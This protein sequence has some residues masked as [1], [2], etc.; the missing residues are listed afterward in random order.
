MFLLEVPAYFSEE[1]CDYLIMLAKH[2]G[3]KKSPL[4]PT[5]FSIPDH[6]SEELFNEWDVDKDGWLSPLEVSNALHICMHRR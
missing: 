2:A 1:E 4:H 5:K 3:L 6:T